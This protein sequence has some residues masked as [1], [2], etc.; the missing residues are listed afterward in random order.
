[1]SIEIKLSRDA[2][3]LTDDDTEDATN[4]DMKETKLTLG[5][6]LSKHVR[7]M[8]DMHWTWG[9]AQRCLQHTNYSLSQESKSQ[10]EILHCNA[11]V[12][13]NLI[14]SCV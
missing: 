14:T 3:D 5:L 13:I 2:T 11:L 6:M 9:K 12:V 4:V 8:G 1:M 7:R 10:L